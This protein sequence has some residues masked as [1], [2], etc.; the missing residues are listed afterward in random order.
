MNSLFFFLIIVIFTLVFLTGQ[1]FIIGCYYT[2]W[3]QH[4]QGF[5]YFNPSNIDPK[6]CTHLYYAF[7]NINTTKRSPD[8][9]E[10]DEIS[11]NGMYRQF[12]R[13]KVQNRQLK[14][15][16]SLGGASVN[17][18][19]FRYVF[20][21]NRIRQDFIRNTIRYLRKYQFNG[22]DLDWEYPMNDNDRQIFTQTIRHY[23]SEFNKE[24]KSTNRSRLLL[25]AAVAAYRPKIE[26][27]YD[28]KEISRY[29]DYINLMSY[30]YHGSWNNFIGFNSPLSVRSDEIDHQRF[31]NQQASVDIWTSHG[32]PPSK[33]VLGL[34]MYG[35]TFRLTEP[36]HRDIKP[37]S[38]ARGP[39]LPGNYTG[40]KGFLA[41]YEICELTTKSQWNM[42][43]DYE[44]EVPFAWKDDQWIGFDNRESIEKK[45]LFIAQE[46]LA[47]AM[48]WSL[49]LDDFRGRFCNE[50]K[51]P[52]LRTI[53]KTL[54]KLKQNSTKTFARN[55]RNHSSARS[56]FSF[57]FF[58]IWSFILIK[59]F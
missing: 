34:G 47:G 21:T 53:R 40:S 33:L 11:S 35:R 3:S 6:L 39:G 51:Y 28:V 7:A 36:F 19:Q 45:C 16:L 14:T 50:G 42:S 13:L 44:Q 31:L 20:K 55:F 59:I 24:A 1:S 25:T 46:R 4:R 43:Y 17:T 37:Y 57:L 29:L 22:L 10:I 8:P 9:F 27:G 41:Y 56:T 48:I 30:D 52:L 49:D 54:E 12:N 2:N 38:P 15:L 58:S 18:S 5:G 32:C 26:I 23:R